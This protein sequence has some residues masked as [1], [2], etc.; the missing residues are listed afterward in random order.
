MVH[1]GAFGGISW[2]CAGA[3]STISATA[4]THIDVRILA[5]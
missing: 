5:R 1:A 2:L 3:L 4:D